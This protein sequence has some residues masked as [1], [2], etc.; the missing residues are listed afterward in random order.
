MCARQGALPCAGDMVVIFFVKCHGSIPNFVF[1]FQSISIYSF[2]SSCIWKAE[3]SPTLKVS[4]LHC[5]FF[6][7]VSLFNKLNNASG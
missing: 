6:V 5:F 1:F 3:R 2:Q 7:V 4:C